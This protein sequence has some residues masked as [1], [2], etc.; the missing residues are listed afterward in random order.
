MIL[1][2]KPFLLYLYLCIFIYKQINTRRFT[3]YEERL[4]TYDND[5]FDVESYVNELELALGTAWGNYLKSL[6]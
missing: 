1:K 5:I 4:V 6:K 3:E 2:R